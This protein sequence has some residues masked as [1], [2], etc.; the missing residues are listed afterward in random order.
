MEEKDLLD[1][2][3]K[4]AFILPLVATSA[5]AIASWAI[6]WKEIEDEREVPALM[7]MR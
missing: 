4:R 2:S 6:K 5:A 7:E 3:I 1:D